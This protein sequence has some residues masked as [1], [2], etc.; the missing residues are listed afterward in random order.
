MKQKSYPVEIDIPVKNASDKRK[1]Y[2]AIFTPGIGTD[3]TR[4]FKNEK[5][6]LENLEVK[7]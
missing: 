1:T 5:S 6:A 7:E 4:R 3:L 2:W